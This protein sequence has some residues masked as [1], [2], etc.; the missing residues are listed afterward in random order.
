MCKHCRRAVL[1]SIV[2]ILLF[3]CTGCGEKEVEQPP[4][5][6]E[7]PPYYEIMKEMFGQDINSV[8]KALELKQ[9]DFS[10]DYPFYTYSKPVEYLGYDFN[11]R[12]VTN[13]SGACVNVT[14]IM[15]LQDD[16]EGA[17]HTV[18]DLRD[19]LMK[20]Y[21]ESETSGYHE[22]R[23]LLETI[24]YDELYKRITDETE[25]GTNGLRWTLDEEVK[26]E[27]DTYMM[28]TCSYG[29]PE[30]N[31]GNGDVSVTIVYALETDR[32]APK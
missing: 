7:Y 9:E 10:F 3:V 1:L 15:L 8:I 32:I 31:I 2:L 26:P 21:G 27:K 11:M 12:L 20:A 5:K 22:G 4:A 25:Q 19:A 17:A 28:I 18:V 13:S 29:Y 6:K 24:T 30:V 23:P 16:P 14:F